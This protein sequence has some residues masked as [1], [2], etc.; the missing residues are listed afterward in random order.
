MLA[1]KGQAAVKGGMDLRRLEPIVRDAAAPCPNGSRRFPE[2]A[3]LVA[4]DL[5]N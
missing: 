3:N 1:G 2:V 5:E 4:S